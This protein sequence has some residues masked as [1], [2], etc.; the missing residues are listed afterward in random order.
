[1]TRSYNVFGDIEGKLGVQGRNKGQA[2]EHG[3]QL[4]GHVDARQFDVVLP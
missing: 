4:V 2:T 1:M 3:P